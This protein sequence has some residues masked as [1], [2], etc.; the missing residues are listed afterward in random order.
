MGPQNTTGLFVVLYILN[1]ICIA[2]YLVMQILLVAN[3]LDD[4]WPLGH[5]SFGVLVFIIGQVL[6]YQ[7]SDVICNNVQHY[8]DGLF[9][10]TFCNLLAVMMIYK[11]RQCFTFMLGVGL[12]VLSFGIQ[13]PRKILNSLLVSN[14]TLGTSRSNCLKRNAGQLFT[15]TTTLSMQAACTTTGRRTTAIIITKRLLFSKFSWPFISLFSGLYM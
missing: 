6:L 1:A 8:L 2:V 12:T 15:Q 11:V 10:A 13:L 3:T 9:F 7:F 14:Q 4:R 5:I